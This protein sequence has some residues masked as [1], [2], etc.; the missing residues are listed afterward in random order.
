VPTRVTRCT[1]AGPQP[2]AAAKL[3]ILASNQETPGSGPGGSANSPNGHRVRKVRFE[4][5]YREVW[6]REVSPVAVTPAWCA[7]WDLN[8]DRTQVK[9]LS[10][11]H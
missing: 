10:L 7:T 2:C 1:R 5:T 3:A 6:A 9:S 4:R 8:P 11:C